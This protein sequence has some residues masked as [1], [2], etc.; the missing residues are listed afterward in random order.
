MRGCS[1][2]DHGQ[3]NDR[4]ANRHL[5]P[6]LKATRHGFEVCLD[7]GDETAASACGVQG[8]AYY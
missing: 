3:L 8:D 4:H 1:I 7:G 6:I 2:F 5:F